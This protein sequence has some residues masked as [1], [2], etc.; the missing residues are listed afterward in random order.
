MER[1]REIEKEFFADD[2]KLIQEWWE[3]WGLQI[4]DAV[5]SDPDGPSIEVVLHRRTRLIRQK[6]HLIFFYFFIIKSSWFP[7]GLAK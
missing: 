3:V 5:A 7:T 6:I 1:A 4:E 2:M